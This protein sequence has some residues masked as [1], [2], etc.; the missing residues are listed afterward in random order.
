MREAI[1]MAQAKRYSDER[2]RLSKRRE[3][4]EEEEVE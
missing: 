4:E 3:A 2:N 1:H